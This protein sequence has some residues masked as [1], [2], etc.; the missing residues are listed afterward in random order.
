MIQVKDNPNLVRDERSNSIL[1][2]NLDEMLKFK[3]NRN[4]NSKLSIEVNELK[5]EISDLKSLLNQVLSK[6]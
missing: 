6:L 1:N 2:T 3:N 4:E 5:S